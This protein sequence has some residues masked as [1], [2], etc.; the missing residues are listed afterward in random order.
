MGWVGDTADTLGKRDT[1]DGKFWIAIG[2]FVGTFVLLVTI[3]C[4]CFACRRYKRR[5]KFKR[6]LNEGIHV[7]ELW[8]RGDGTAPL[9]DARV[10]MQV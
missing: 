7:E 3:A 8:E 4:G 10:N 5:Q 2:V 6:E 1:S 9:Q